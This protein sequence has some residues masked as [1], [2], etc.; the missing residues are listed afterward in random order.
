MDNI[1]R[2]IHWDLSEWEYSR[3]GILLDGDFVGGHESVECIL[4]YNL[5]KLAERVD[6]SFIFKIFVNVK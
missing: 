1:I 6:S 4:S 2:F 3:S 5:D